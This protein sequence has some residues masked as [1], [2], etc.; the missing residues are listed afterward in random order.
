MAATVIA[1]DATGIFRT[2]TIDKGS[3][4]GLRKDMAVIAPEG[5]VGRIVE[6]PSLYAAKVQL[7]IDKEA[8]AGAII[9]RSGVG[10]VVV[11][12][13]RDGEPPLDLQFV[14]NLSDAKVGDRLVTSGLDSIFP[15]G[16]AIGTLVKVEKGVGLYKRIAV[17]PAVDFAEVGV[18]LVVLDPPQTIGPSPTGGAPATAGD[19]DPAGDAR[20]AP[21]HA[22]GG[23]WRRD[24]AGQAARRRQPSDPA[25]ARPT[26]PAPDA[27]ASGRDAA[28]PRTDRFGAPTPP[29]TAGPE[30]SAGPDACAARDAAGRARTVAAAAGEAAMKGATVG[31]AIIVALALQ[32][33]PVF[34]RHGTGVDLVLVVVVWTALQ[35]G[36]AAGLMTGAAAGLAQDVLS[37]GI[38]GVGGF[39]KTLVGFGAGAVGSQ[40]IVANAPTRFVVLVIG[41]VVNELVFLGLYAAIERRGFDMPWRQAGARALATAVVGIVLMMASKAMAAFL[42]RRR[43]RRGY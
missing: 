2:L 3:S 22:S 14:S 26:G 5:V 29:Q 21:G 39:A 35:F 6:P 1:G 19:G 32:T 10:G 4:S 16:I 11:G 43:L 15:R 31:L 13:D 37:A 20:G 40:F 25:R 17:A 34:G 41:A 28:H 36:P 24:G 23:A 38:I 18:V 30:T 7:L 33:S 42:T 12:Q 9:E 8:G 27:A